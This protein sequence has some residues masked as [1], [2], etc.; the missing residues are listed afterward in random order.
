MNQEASSL[1]AEEWTQLEKDA[2]LQELNEETS[3]IVFP[4]LVFCVLIMT[5]G[6][7]GNILVFVVYASQF[8][9][10]TTRVFIMAMS[11]C[12][13]FTSVIT[14]S[15]MI[16]RLRHMYKVPVPSLCVFLGT[17]AH[18]PIIM[19]NNLLICM[20]MDRWRRVC[21]PVEWQLSPLHASQLV[22][23]CSI[24]STFFVLPVSL[25]YGERRFDT[26][27]AGLQGRICDFTSTDNARLYGRYLLLYV[28][29]LLAFVGFSYGNI[30]FRLYQQDKKFS[31]KGI[32][33][34]QSSTSIITQ[35]KKMSDSDVIEVRSTQSETQCKSLDL[36]DAP[37]T[38]ASKPLTNIRPPASP[39]E[40]VAATAS[41]SRKQSAVK[42]VK[43]TEKHNSVND[44]KTRVSFPANTT[45]EKKSTLPTEA[46]LLST[47]KSDSLGHAEPSLDTRSSV[48]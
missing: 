30:I 2:K 9:P 47:R 27:Y 31:T 44:M 14:L 43:Q 33:E 16:H 35:G 45:D 5:I 40:S 21:R 28:A 1:T 8:R 41:T 15:F 37:N 32:M 22:V 7:P 39:R 4:S 20:A 13:L 24:L 10:S 36:K 29:I 11:F 26:K 18:F 48:D 17:A 46:P 34:E 38:V 42:K 12:D 3:R 25:L 19:S 23:M 6:I